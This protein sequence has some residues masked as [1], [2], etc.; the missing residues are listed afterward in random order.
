MRQIIQKLSFSSFLL[1][2]SATNSPWNPNSRYSKNI[3]TRRG[4]GTEAEGSQI[5]V[6]H[7]SYS[8]ASVSHSI[9]SG[10]YK[11]NDSSKV[12]FQIA[13][14]N[15]LSK[16]RIQAKD[17]PIT[18]FSTTE[19]ERFAAILH[20]DSKPH[21]YPEIIRQIQQ[22]GKEFTELTGIPNRTPKQK[23][24]V[25]IMTQNIIQLYSELLR[26]LE[27]KSAQQE[28]DLL[29]SILHQSY[30]RIKY[31]LTDSDDDSDDDYYPQNFS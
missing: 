6:G 8:E 28:I 19:L 1:L 18:I 3:C 5:S 27:E 16:D 20:D 21:Q 29:S 31:E 22:L 14:R 2:C 12:S 13:A 25:F 15:Q 17:S 11:G 26:Q 9:H 10:T 30:D 7:F 4:G 23:E 24:Q